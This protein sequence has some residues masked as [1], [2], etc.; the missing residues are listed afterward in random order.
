MDETREE[1]TK[2]ESQ[3]PLLGAPTEV[4]TREADSR[5]LILCVLLGQTDGETDRQTGGEEKFK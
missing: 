5:C 2:E 3:H 1:K 4:P